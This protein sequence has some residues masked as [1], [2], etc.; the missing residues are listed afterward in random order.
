MLSPI[1]ILKSAIVFVAIED[2]SAFQRFES[3]H[4]DFLKFVKLFAE[5]IS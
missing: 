5:T 2:H 1:P 3:E 4:V